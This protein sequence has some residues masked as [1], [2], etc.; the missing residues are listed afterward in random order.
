MSDKNES[1]F[2]IGSFL[3][4]AAVGAALGVLFAPDKG[5]E[6]RKKINEKLEEYKN[7]IEALFADFSAM[8]EKGMSAS[9][10]ESRKTADIIA[11]IESLITKIKSSEQG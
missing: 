3:A 4:G 7:K 11:E 2:G 6:T 5:S 9:E 10:E 1:S 8:K